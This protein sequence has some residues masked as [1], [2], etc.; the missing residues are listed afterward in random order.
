MPRLTMLL[1]FAVV[2]SA[3]SAAAH[4]LVMKPGP[5]GL[6][7]TATVNRALPADIV[8]FAVTVSHESDKE[9][10]AA[11]LAGERAPGLRSALIARGYSVIGFD[12][13]NI[14]ARKQTSRIRAQTERGLR[15]QVI[16][17]INHTDRHPGLWLRNAGRRHPT[18][19]RERRRADQ[20]PQ[21][22]FDP[23]GE[24]Q[25]GI[26]I[27]RYRQGDGRSADLGRPFRFA[28]RQCGERQC[29]A[30]DR[31]PAQHGRDNECGLTGATRP[32]S[33]LCVGDRDSDLRR[34]RE[35]LVAAT[36]KQRSHAVSRLSRSPETPFPD[37]AIRR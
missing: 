36:G 19:C 7:S 35:P 11:K 28:A 22:R 29:S 18:R 32:K 16:T 1:L 17:K 12:I 5:S 21:L 26:G 20:S 33:G 14:T 37:G 4:A 6:T 27:G 24:H 3:W 31:E 23:I 13:T 9:E 10:D 34:C 15:Q 8:Q 25:E 2:S 30:R